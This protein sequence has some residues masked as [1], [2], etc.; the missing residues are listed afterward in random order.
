[1][2]IYFYLELKKTLTMKDKYM[3]FYL[4]TGGGHL[5][6][7][8]SVA[9]K[10]KNE[11][12]ANAEI[13]LVDGLNESKHFVKKIL[14]DGYKNSVNKAVWTFEFLYALHKIRMVS[15]ITASIISYFVKPGIEKQIL[16]AKPSKIAVF[17]FF[18]VKPIVEI[19]KKH[20]LEI[21]MITVVTDPFT[22]HPI[23]FLQK[24]INYLV[25]SES[26]KQK[27]I[28]K[29]I[30][31]NNLQVF[32]FPLNSKYSQNISEL[33]KERIR[34]IHGF[35]PKSKMILVI[36]GGDGMPSGMKILKNILSKN[37][38]AEIAIVCG[39]NTK[40]F[41]QAMKLKN[42]F[43]L[44]KLKV[45]GFIDYVYSLI[46]IS[47]VVITKCGPS[48]IMEIL[49]MGKVPVINNYIWEQE[50]GNMEF[51]CKHKM[52]LLE[53]RTKRLPDLLQKLIT[54]NDFYNSIATNI[55]N[56]TLSN[57]VGQVSDYILN[58]R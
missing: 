12:N 21:P 27:C 16:E 23:W 55:K 34:T 1:M 52:G 5:S 43:K 19:V 28:D 2:D 30:N 25:F 36:G 15:K 10:M 3:F 22:A 40:L 29:G 9:E 24:D 51:V 58:F 44:G 41:N 33:E 53:K 42:K 37:V 7:A 57:G 4:K 49:L 38:D 11:Q 13:I 26:L 18:L 31:E 6:T 48:T 46:G 56:A 17:H 35:S 32:P 50:K 20:N 8:K 14:E 47:D 54:D 39:K 45:F